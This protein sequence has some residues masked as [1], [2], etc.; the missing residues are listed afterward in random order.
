MTGRADGQATAA[1]FCTWRP[2]PG[3]L[4]GVC[5]ECD[6][7]DLAHV[8]TPCCIVCAALGG[9]LV[10]D[11]GTVI[12]NLPGMSSAASAVASEDPRDY[13]LIATDLRRAADRLYA[14]DDSRLEV[15]TWDHDTQVRYGQIRSHL[16]SLADAI[17]SKVA[18]P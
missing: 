18:K 15:I 8:R 7:P 5:P 4:V 12:E 6:H 17:S 14:P 1:D 3:W 11:D 9:Y 2:P 10:R 13:G 16:R